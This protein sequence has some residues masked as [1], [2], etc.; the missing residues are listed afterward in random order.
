MSKKLKQG[1]VVSSLLAGLLTACPIPVQQASFSVT[2]EIFGSSFIDGTDIQ[3]VEAT[4]KNIG[5]FVGTPPEVTFNIS[6]D[7]EFSSLDNTFYA[8][9]TPSEILLLCQAK[10]NAKLEP[11]A[12]TKLKPIFAVVAKNVPLTTANSRNLK[13][14]DSGLITF[15]IGIGSPVLPAPI[16]FSGRSITASTSGFDLIVGKTVSKPFI[17]GPNGGTGEFTITATVTGTPLPAYVKI[18]DPPLPVGFSYDIATTNANNPAWNCVAAAF[19]GLGISCTL[20]T[21]PSPPVPVAGQY[22]A[23]KLTVKMLSSVTT[24]TQLNCP[25]LYPLLGDTNNNNN[26]LGPAPYTTSCTPYTPIRTDL[27]IVKTQIAP[28]TTPANSFYWDLPGKYQIVVSNNTVPAAAVS[29]PFT[30][31]DVLSNLPTGSVIAFTQNLADVFLAA[32]GWTITEPDPGIFIPVNSNGWYCLQGTY[33]NLTCKHPGPIAANGTLPPL[34]LGVKVKPES[35][36][37]ANGET[38]CASLPNDFNNSNNQSCVTSQNQ[39]I[40]PFD[41]RIIKTH[42]NPAVNPIAG[43]IVN[44]ALQIDNIGGS[45]AAGPITVMDTLPAAFSSATATVTPASAAVCTVT[46]PIIKCVSS[47]SLSSGSSFTINI[48]ATSSGTATGTIINTASVSSYLNAADTNL[49]NN[50]SSDPVTFGV[51]INLNRAESTVQAANGDFIVVGSSDSATRGKQF[52]VRRY[53]SDGT[54]VIW[55][56]I[57]DFSSADDTA[58]DVALDTLGNI[59]VVGRSNLTSLTACDTQAVLTKYDSSGVVLV[60]F[61]KYVGTTS[62]SKYDYFS[63]VALDSS[64][65]IVTGGSDAQVGSTLCGGQAESRFTVHR[66]TSTGAADSIF[67]TLGRVQTDVSSLL[68]HTTTNSA[69][70]AFVQD[71]L[72]EETSDQYR[73]YAAGSSPYIT[74]RA[75]TVARYT[76]TGTLDNTW[77]ASTASASDGVGVIETNLTNGAIVTNQTQDSVIREIGIQNINGVKRLIATGFNCGGTGNCSDSGN[78]AYRKCVVTSYTTS[79]GALDT[80]FGSSGAASYGLVGSTPAMECNAMSIKS[81]GQIAVAGSSHTTANGNDYL[82]MTLTATGGLINTYG[83]DNPNAYLGTPAISPRAD[84][85]WG[86]IWTA[87]GNILTVGYSDKDAT[88]KDEW[89]VKTY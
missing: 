6:S 54:T 13:P 34:V 80:A 53:A 9:T 51:P 22:P 15:A 39:A 3:P 84:A 64:N 56:K 46:F 77:G 65:R 23:L 68:G 70:G 26:H 69:L 83:S 78:V 1:L 55:T 25:W 38:N 44:Y 49:A 31:T 8:C 63:S 40:E 89:V 72:V 29:G 36:G 74:L 16:N 43:S 10:E 52:A 30:I 42:A 20:K 50:T 24:A 76:T 12:S 73:I 88:E 47:G 75:F 67:G 11:Q 18:Q 79:N 41:L 7:L 85:S 57:E 45:D 21:P 2:G 81:T 5:G 86:V 71:V 37:L 60:G 32:D 66:F 62:D 61:P 48:A 87:A 14:Q 19:S 17:L 27:A 33:P 4:V 58:F 82:A 28:L 59:V 35:V